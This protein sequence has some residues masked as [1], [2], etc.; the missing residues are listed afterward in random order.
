M[1]HDFR[2]VGDY[3]TNADLAVSLAISQ[4]W[5]HL[6]RGRPEQCLRQLEPF[7]FDDGAPYSPHNAVEFKLTQASALIALGL[8]CGSQ[9]R[10]VVR[11]AQWR[12]ESA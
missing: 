8:R 7:N 1:E 9:L 11:R 2:R 12:W 6:A 3:E 10:F 4:G 5:W